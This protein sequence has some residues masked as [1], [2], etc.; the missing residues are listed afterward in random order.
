MRFVVFV[1]KLSSGASRAGRPGQSDESSSVERPSRWVGPMHH[2]TVLAPLVAVVGAIVLTACNP[3]PS[4]S[5]ALQALRAAA[6]GLDTT[7][8]YERVWLDGP[9]W[10]SCAEVIAKFATSTDS[11]AVRNQVGNWR[12][13]VVSGWLVLRDSARGVV[14]DPGWCTG[15]LTDEPARRAGGWI[16]IVGDSFPTHVL[17]RGW[18]VPVGKRQLAVVGAPRAAG[19]DS[20]TVEYV[21]TIVPNANGVATGADRDSTFGIAALRK[22]GGVWQLVSSRLAGSDRAPPVAGR[23][24]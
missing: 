17:R 15:K 3:A 16:P 5:E 10:F 23:R 22:V 12:P 6:P 21:A 7:T 18:R 2:R 20:A 8:A 24:R 9:P 14:S 11:A 1:T 4:R 13:L 19:T